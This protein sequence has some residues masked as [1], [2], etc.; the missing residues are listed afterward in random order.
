MTARTIPGYTLAQSSQ[1]VTR[2]EAHACYFDAQRRNASDHIRNLSD[3]LSSTHTES[4]LLLRQD[5]H[6]SSFGEF[7][8][9]SAMDSFSSFS[10]PIPSEFNGFA[11]RYVQSNLQEAIALSAEGGGVI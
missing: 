3:E 1:G 5:E 11:R 8:G 4:E 7:H 10:T 2:F 9:G 6:L